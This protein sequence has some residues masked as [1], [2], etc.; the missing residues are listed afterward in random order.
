MP[1]IIWEGD[2]AKSN[3]SGN[4]LSQRHSIRLRVGLLIMVSI[5]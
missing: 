3:E 4:L 1:L 2:K 5:H